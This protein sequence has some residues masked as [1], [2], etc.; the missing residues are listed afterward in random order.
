[1]H[2]QTFYPHTY[3]YSTGQVLHTGSSSPNS[4]AALTLEDGTQSHFAMSDDLSNG[5]GHHA[6]PYSAQSIHQAFQASMQHGQ[7]YQQHTQQGLPAGM[8]YQLSPQ[9]MQTYLAY[10]SLAP[11]GHQVMN[12]HSPISSPAQPYHPMHP[13]PM[14]PVMSHSYSYQ[15]PASQRSSVDLGQHQYRPGQFTPVS[16]HSL[17]STRGNGGQHLRQSTVDSAFSAS[18]PYS[19]LERSAGPSSYT[20]HSSRIAA[21]GQA[22]QAPTELARGHLAQSKFREALGAYDPNARLPISANER[23]RAASGDSRLP[24]PPAHSP[25]AM[26]VGNVPSDATHS[27]LWRFFSSRA[28]PGQPEPG[29][30][31]EVETLESEALHLTIDQPRPD[32]STVGIDSIHL[33][34]RSNCCFVNM[35]SK[36]HLEHA[37]KVSHGLSLRPHD[38]RCKPLVC[39]VRKKEDD[40]KTGVGAQRGKGMHQAWAAEKEKEK[41]LAQAELD[42]INGTLGDSASVTS[43][44][45]RSD[46]APVR[47]SSVSTNHSV[48]T[49]STT[50]SFLQRHFPKRYFILKVCILINVLVGLDYLLIP[51]TVS[52]RG[53]SASFGRTR[54]VGNSEPQ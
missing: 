14:S 12:G 29:S 38:P 13:P 1:M 28:P 52:L 15:Q 48:S 7:Q 11:Q 34:S 39:R 16:P 37:I 53:R 51:L 21:N 19:N 24:K 46:I 54:P 32:Y 43:P 42:G 20:P 8:T 3:Y 18:T 25:W 40:T 30:S 49:S 10:N 35:A 9:P 6:R 45:V 41:T 4:A 2:P 44:G 36:R 27:E 17:A 22:Q 33:I 47:N 5:H 23:K 26:W 31:E 50:S